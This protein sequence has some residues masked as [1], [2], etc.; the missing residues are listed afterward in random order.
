[1]ST[2]HSSEKEINVPDTFANIEHWE[3]NRRSFLRAA[4]IAGAASQI[5]WFT[6]CSTELEAANDYLTAEQSTILKSIQEIIWPN[7][8]NGPSA[9]DLNTF[10]Y[11]L[12]VFGNNYNKHEDRKYLI[13]GLN[14]ADET[15]QEIY[16]KK[17]V[18]LD[19]EEKD[20]ITE[21]FTKLNWG[22]NWMSIM[23]TL[24]MESVLLDPIYGGNKNEAGWKWLEHKAGIPRPTEETRFEAF[25]SNHKSF[26]E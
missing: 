2:K 17:Y 4:L 10:G 8:G 25:V 9:D 19:Q 1:M 15:S 20:A 22:K 16:F 26:T 14:W 13:E 12:W 24:V 6:S 18:A 7:D 21:K 5:A 11:T 3:T 23:V